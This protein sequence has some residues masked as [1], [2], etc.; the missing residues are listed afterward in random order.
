[1]I[2]FLFAKYKIRFVDG[3]LVKPEKDAANY[4]PWMRCD[5][6]IKGWLTTAMEKDIRSSVKYAK[7]AAEIWN[8]LLERFG[9]ESAP[10]AYELKQSLTMTRQDGATASAYYTKL[11][12]LWDEMESVIPT[13]QCSCNGV[14]VVSGKSLL[15]R[16]T[17]KECMSF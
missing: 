9:K 13:P 11:R 16:K 3:T 1:M 5:A 6:M 15:N 7:T 14:H 8:D 17:R 10:K 4:M 2:I 12:S